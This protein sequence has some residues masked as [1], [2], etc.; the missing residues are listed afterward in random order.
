MKNH[1]VFT[2]LEYVCYVMSCDFAAPCFYGGSD[3]TIQQCL[4]PLGNFMSNDF[5]IFGRITVFTQF[6]QKCK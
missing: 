2:K 6:K 4:D 5:L 3:R 1:S